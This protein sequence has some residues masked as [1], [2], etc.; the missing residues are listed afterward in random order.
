MNTWRIMGLLTRCW[1]LSLLLGGSV[2]ALEPTASE[3]LWLQQHA[4]RPLTLGVVN[5]TGMEQ[6]DY[7]GKPRGYAQ[8]LA[9]LIEQRLGVKI[10]L[11]SGHSWSDTYHRF[12]DGELDLLLGAN[13][14]PQRRQ[15]MAFT[16]RS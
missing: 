5:V 2:L 6:F 4:G 8:D 11:V 13:E 12:L 15:Q 10:T 1:W 16:P 7:A 14:T 3:Q 9:R